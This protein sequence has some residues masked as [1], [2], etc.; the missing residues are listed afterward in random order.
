[1]CFHCFHYT[2]RPV[3]WIDGCESSDSK[4]INTKRSLSE[5]TLS[6]SITRLPCIMMMKMMKRKTRRMINLNESLLLSTYVPLFNGC[7]IV[8]TL[9]IVI[10]IMKYHQYFVPG[11]SRGGGVAGGPMVLKGGMHTNHR[12]HSS[13]VP[14]IRI[15]EKMKTSKMMVRLSLM[16]INNN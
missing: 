15:G 1:M 2:T 11:K 6:P 3:R 7:K 5:I 12:Q 13:P 4:N 10:I 9:L 14:G 16:S 8:P